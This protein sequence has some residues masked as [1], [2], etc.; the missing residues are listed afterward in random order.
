M[1]HKNVIYLDGAQFGLELELIGVDA[2]G[3]IQD[4]LPHLL[5]YHG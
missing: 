4:L 2:G 5:G 1:L 3:R